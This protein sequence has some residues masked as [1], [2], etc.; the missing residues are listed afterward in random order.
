LN[1]TSFYNAPLILDWPSI[2]GGYAYS[3]DLSG[4]AVPDFANGTLAS[5]GHW[6]FTPGNSGVN[7]YDL[8]LKQEIDV[9]E[10]DT[11][12]AIAAGNATYDLSAFFS[13]Y[14]GQADRAF[15]QLDFLGSG[16]SDLGMATLSTPAGP[17]LQDWTMFSIDGSVPVGTETVRVSSWGEVFEGS[18]GSAD[19]YQDNIDFRILDAT[20][21]QIGD[22]NE[23]GVVDA[24]DYAV[25]RDNLGGST[26]LPN[27]GGLGTPIDQDHYD[28]WRARFGEGG[29]GGAAVPEPTTF[30][31]AGVGLASLVVS[32]RL[33]KRDSDA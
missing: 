22:Y 25:W 29:T 1:F 28:Q 3:H 32:R 4:M 23:N 24:G 30:V 11:A 16:G 9:S 14:D 26:A 21:E 17:A 8:A 12:T 31:L 27:D 7:D 13:T 15:I 19:G 5:G 2:V 20:A 10:G 6:Y 33:S 18:T